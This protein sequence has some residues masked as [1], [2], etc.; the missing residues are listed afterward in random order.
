M[1]ADLAYGPLPPDHSNPGDAP[2]RTPS[3]GS[4]DSVPKA[5]NDK[6][7]APVARFTEL[8]TLG[9]DKT[10]VTDFGL[11]HARNLPT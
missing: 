8:K 4:Y 10:R 11:K 3:P 1:Q 2:L 7:L 5:I 6:E 9:S